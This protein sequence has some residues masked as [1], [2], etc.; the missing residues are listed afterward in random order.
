MQIICISRGSYG[1]GKKLAEKL[2][3]KLGYR[4]ISREMLTDKAT[5]SGIP[6]G[7]A[8]MAIVK[9]R[10]LSEE[11]A[12]EVDLFKA[13]IT[14]SLCETALAE[15]GIV[16][17]GRTGHLV[18]PG[19]THIMRVRAIANMEER[20]TL[21]MNRMNLTREKAK[22]YID[23]VDEDI[24]RW[25][26]TLYNIDWDDPSLYD[27]NIS[28][29]HLSVESSASALMQMVK[30]PEFMPTPA[31]QQ[32]L[33]DLLLAA[34]CRLAIGKD[35]RTHSVKAT[36][37]AGKGNVS[38]TYLPRQAK[39]AEA[40]PSVLE[41]ID[42]IKSLICTVATTNILF[43][44]ELFDPNAQSLHDLIE[45]AEKWNAAVELVR[46]ADK[47]GGRVSTQ[48]EVFP[49]AVSG[50]YNGGILDDSEPLT[51]CEDDGCGVPETVDRLIQAGRAGG[52]YAIYGDPSELIGGLNRTEN[53]SLV[54][55]GDLF[56]SRG[57]VVRKRM[58]RDLISLLSEKFHIPVIGTEDLKARYL[59]RPRQLITLAGYGIVAAL[60]YLGT[61]SFQEQ[62][63][64][65]LHSTQTY[66]KIAAAVIVTVFV[67]I[68]AFCIGGFYH[69]VLRLI[70]IE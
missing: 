15:E 49:I 43:L 45:I 25:V 70:K 55:V 46:F 39:L 66:G 14:A 54:V 65:F 59:F 31:S 27:L 57:E 40:I 1:Y 4:C 37:K 42:G 61:F 18:L 53:L 6:V 12:V 62:I 51:G 21:A 10:P 28:S 60:L 36:V 56:L 38:V 24:R 13:F 22:I 32:V 8:E 9:R 63:L 41:K 30:L 35:D 33:D 20:I 44:Q 3:S 7:K 58:R 17:H 52:S 16:Y 67:P 29:D 48:E 23:Q 68:S 47:K 11:M 34:R 5:D 26:R 50:E 19:V 69:N 64:G 2:A